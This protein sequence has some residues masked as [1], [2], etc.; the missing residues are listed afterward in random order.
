MARAPD[1]FRLNSWR[2]QAL[3]FAA[4]G[5]WPVG[6]AIAVL[7][8]PGPHGSGTTFALAMLPFIAASAYLIFARLRSRIEV[9]DDTV[10]LYLFRTRRVPLAEASEFVA[11]PWRGQ[12]GE[13]RVTVAEVYLHR[14]SGEQ[15]KIGTMYQSRRGE[16]TVA[17][18]NALLEAHRPGASPAQTVD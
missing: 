15:L 14:S 9:S 12:G 11:G 17:D 4:L 8:N 1:A 5:A 3:F 10:T 18:L 2:F 16:R 13:V 6:L 7:M